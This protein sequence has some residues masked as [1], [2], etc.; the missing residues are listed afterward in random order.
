MS[1]AALPATSAAR[2][3]T[4]AGVAPLAVMILEL[5]VLHL[6]AAFGVGH[7]GELLG[8]RVLVCLGNSLCKSVPDLSQGLVLLVSASKK[9][10]GVLVFPEV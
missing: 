5:D 4:V 3:E 2:L 10:W 9:L 7:S 1:V 6:E 8:P